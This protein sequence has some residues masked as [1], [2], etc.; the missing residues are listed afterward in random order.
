[1][2]VGVETEGGGAVSSVSVTVFIYSHLYTDSSQ[3]AGP[4]GWRK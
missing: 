3:A 1:M 4:L 2:G